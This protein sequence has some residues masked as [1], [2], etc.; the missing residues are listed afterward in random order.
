MF[1]LIKEAIKFLL[2]LVSAIIGIL[3]LKV[4]NVFDIFDFFSIIPDGYEYD[5]GITVYFPIISLAL[6]KLFAKSALFTSEIEVLLSN[7]SEEPLIHFNKNDLAEVHLIIRITGKRKHF[8][9][10][11]VVIPQIS[12]CT[13]QSSCKCSYAYVD[14]FGNYVVNL[15]NLLGQANKVEMEREFKLALIKEPEESRGKVCVSPQL[16][17]KRKLVTFKHNHVSITM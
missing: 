17:G 14:Q 5:L 12:G 9:P 3:L 10:T 1:I 6:E 13:M 7:R 11:S 2:P 15:C 8:M 16:R 4:I